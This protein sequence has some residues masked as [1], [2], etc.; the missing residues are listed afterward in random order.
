M[1]SP[2]MYT[3]P[4]GEFFWLIP[5]AIG[6]TI[7]AYT[8]YQMAVNNG[9]SGWA[10]AGYIIG[11]AAISGISGVAGAG[12][13]AALGATLATVSIG[14]FVGGAIVGGVVGTVSGS[15]A[16]A[17]FAMLG[18]ASGAD[19]WKS[20]GKGAL[21]GFATGAVLGGITQGI[22]ALEDSKTFWLGK[23]TTI[24]APPSDYVREDIK[25]YNANYQET[26]DIKLPEKLYKYTKDYPGKWTEI[27]PGENGLA[28][29]TTDGNLGKLNASLDLSLPGY[30]PNYRIE[31]ITSDPNFNFSNI[32]FIRP[33]N[34]NVFG[35][36]GGGWEV[37]Y[38]GVYSPSE[39]Y[40]LTVSPLKY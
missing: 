9:A 40:K 24:T 11:G 33:V 15:I 20:M 19:I 6:A 18:G 37:I 8:G 5:L 31:I 21:I 25:P 3:D 38:R 32:E 14:G 16:G 2:L 27:K 30:Q 7:G 34:G 26:S 13:G 12:I 10:M 1:N 29:Y 22:A 4:S 35:H 39:F 28:F 36:G 23:E 17:G